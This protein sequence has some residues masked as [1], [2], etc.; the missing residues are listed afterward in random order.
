MPSLRHVH[1]DGEPTGDAALHR[2]HTLA[3]LVEA[4]ATIDDDLLA[5]VEADVTPAERMVIVHTSG[6][7]SA[8]K[9]VIHEHGPLVRPSR[10]PQRLRRLTAGVKLFSN[11]PMFWIGGLAYNVVGTL[12]AGATLLCP[13]APTRE[14]LDFVERERPELVNGFAQSIAA[15]AARPDVRGTRLHVDPFRQ[16]VPDRA[17][18]CP[19]RDPELRHNMLG[20]TETG[21]VCLMSPT[22]A[23][24]P[25][26]GAG[27]SGA[28]AR[29][30]GAR[31][32]S[33]DLDGA[34]DR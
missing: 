13:T 9:G 22:S 1:L 15:L 11:S 8:P 17:R 33:R 3:T 24:S 7:T 23:T 2:D 12:V 27:R 19:A 16:P 6:S 5:A 21:S 28:R 26:T 10:E 31:R 25:S 32:R 18:G 34:T 30:R 29:A 4:G 14:A 20:M